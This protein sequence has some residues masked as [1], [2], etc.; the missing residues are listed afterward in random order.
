M[1]EKEK[2]I[3]AAGVL[4]GRKQIKEKIALYYELG[5]PIMDNGHL[6]WLKGEMENL[7]DIMD[8]IQS[9]WE[10]DMKLVKGDLIKDG[11]N[12]YTLFCIIMSVVYVKPYVDKV[13]NEYIELSE[14]LLCYRKIEIIEETND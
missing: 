2:E 3:F 14:V 11:D 13:H 10:E 12:F 6:Y 8:D 9:T 7:K 4:L 1:T 5:K